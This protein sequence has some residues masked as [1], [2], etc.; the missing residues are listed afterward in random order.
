MAGKKSLEEQVA[1]LQKQFGGLVKLVKDLKTSVEALEKKEIP[2]EKDEV[3]EIL[4]AQKV[5]DKIIASNTESIKR[6]DKEINELKSLERHTF[7]EMLSTIK[8]L[9]VLQI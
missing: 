3:K 4:E 2:N 1:L 6:A 7:I 5:I 9:L 8:I